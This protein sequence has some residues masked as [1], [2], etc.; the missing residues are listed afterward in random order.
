M[1]LLLLPSKTMDRWAV[2]NS[3]EHNRI[4][5]SKRARV[6]YRPSSSSNVKITVHG[7]SG[8]LRLNIYQAALKDVKRTGRTKAKKVGF[9][10][11][12]TYNSLMGEPETSSEAIWISESAQTITVGCDPEFVIV[13]SSGEAMYADN[14]IPYE[15]REGPFGSDGPCVELRPPPS[16]KISEVV[17][18]MKSLLNANAHLIEKYS[19]LGGASYTHPTMNRSFYVGGH[20]HFG[21]PRGI[22]FAN[23]NIQKRVVRILDELVAVP[24]VRIDAPNPSMRRTIPCSGSGKIYGAFGDIREGSYKFEWR[25][26][27]GIWLIHPDLA[28][29]VL[30]TAKAVVEEVWKRFEDNDKDTEF[31]MSVTRKNNLQ[32]SFGCEDSE[33]IRKIINNSKF[34]DVST[35]Q[36]RKQYQKLKDMATYNKYS[37]QIDEFINICCS[38]SMPPSKQRLNLKSGWINNKPF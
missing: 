38:K 1:Q 36:V 10:T 6:Y 7:K 29:C 34:S 4:R 18:S 33:K 24:L 8:Q 21:L 32:N 22:K 14:I 2:K 9:V 13:D 37:P 12:K 15:L 11:T 19:W 26:P 31:M 20:M 16:N 27:S 3:Q 28:E 35:T 30:T 25:V 17:E 23:T 5:L